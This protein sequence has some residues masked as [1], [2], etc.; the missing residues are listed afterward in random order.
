[1]GALKVVAAV[2]AASAVLT[3]CSA[4]QTPIPPSPSASASG[5]PVPLGEP[6][7]PG[8]D[9]ASPVATDQDSGFS[10]VQGT[11]DGGTSL[12][13]LLMGEDPYPFAASEAIIKIV[14][15]MTGDGDELSVTLTDPEGMRQSLVWGPE[16]HGGSSYRRPGSEWGT[17]LRLDAPGC[18]TLEL[19]RD[20]DG[21]ASV[22]F[23]VA[24]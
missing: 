19:S 3:G 13:G 9:P 20:V 1:M 23:D 10:E 18:W 15:R 4:V 17:G 11:S 24:P 2:G 8:C 16:Y 6:G 7:R 5:T 22:Y 14:W 12:Y 21:E